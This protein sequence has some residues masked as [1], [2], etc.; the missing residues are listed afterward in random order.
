M[1]SMSPVVDAVEGLF[2]GEEAGRAQG[3][4]RAARLQVEGG[5]RH[6]AG[7]GRRPQA[8][9]QAAHHRP[10]D[11]VAGRRVGAADAQRRQPEPLRSPPKKTQR[12]VIETAT[13][14]HQSE[15]S[16]SV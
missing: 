10:V 7:A 8:H 5:R 15:P 13:S 1:V 9:G 2:A 12:P 3:Q 4:A 6:T 11:A 16:N 14:V